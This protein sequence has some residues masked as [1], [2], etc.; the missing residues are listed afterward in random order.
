MLESVFEKEMK[1]VKMHKYLQVKRKPS[2][3]LSEKLSADPIV[4][5]YTDDEHADEPVE[6]NKIKLKFKI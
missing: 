6:K 3:R 1:N 4:E 5:E 2:R